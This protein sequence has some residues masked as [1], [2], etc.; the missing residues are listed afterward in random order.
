MIVGAYEGTVYSTYVKTY[1]PKATYVQFSSAASSYQGVLDQS[2]HAI[3]GDAIQYRNW[4]SL[5]GNSCKGCSVSLFGDSYGFATFTAF[6][7]TSAG[8]SYQVVSNNVGM[9]AILISLIIS[10]IF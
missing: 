10:F 1:L 5:N 4:M 2:V 7:S 9:L 3:I 8:V 6:N